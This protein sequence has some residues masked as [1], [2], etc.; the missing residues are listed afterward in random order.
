MR[1]GR[2]INW[3]KRMLGYTD[4]FEE[5]DYDEEELP[6]HVKEFMRKDLRKP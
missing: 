1:I 2:F 3:I 4:P 5:I 6:P